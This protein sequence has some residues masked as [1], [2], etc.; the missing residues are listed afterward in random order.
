VCCVARL[1]CAVWGYPPPNVR[2]GVLRPAKAAGKLI[3]EYVD[4]NVDMDPEWPT[5]AEETAT[6]SP[7][8]VAAAA[9]TARMLVGWFVG[10]LTGFSLDSTAKSKRNAWEATCADLQ[11]RTSRVP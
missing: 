9:G 11:R 4:R 6:P 2:V 5:T 8:A 10:G 3:S 7:Q 1:I